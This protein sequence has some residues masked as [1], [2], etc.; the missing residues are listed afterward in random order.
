MRI[1]VYFLTC[2]DIHSEYL[3]YKKLLNG[4]EFNVRKASAYKSYT[5]AS[6][7]WYSEVIFKLS[8]EKGRGFP[9]PIV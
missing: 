6:A 2:G 7:E 5:I 4:S 1:S 8:N 3:E 9:H